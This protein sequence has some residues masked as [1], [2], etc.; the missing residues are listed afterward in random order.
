MFYHHL[1][2]LQSNV[3]YKSISLCYFIFIISLNDV[4]QVPLAVNRWQDAIIAS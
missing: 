1:H 4:Q 3:V 2:V